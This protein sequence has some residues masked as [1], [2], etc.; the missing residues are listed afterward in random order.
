MNEHT[1]DQRDNFIEGIKDAR[2]G[3]VNP[4]GL[5]RFTGYAEGVDYANSNEFENDTDAWNDAFTTYFPQE[6]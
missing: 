1:A 5:P 4:T 2:N 3:A 6:A